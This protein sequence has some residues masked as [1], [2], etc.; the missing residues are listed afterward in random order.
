MGK[1]TDYILQPVGGRQ[2][3]ARGYEEIED[4][5]QKSCRR[6]AGAGDRPKLTGSGG[7]LDAQMVRSVRRRLRRLRGML[8]RN[9]QKLWRLH[10]TQW[11][12]LEAH[13]RRSPD[14]LRSMG[15]RRRHRW[16]G[17]ADLASLVDLERRQ[18]IGCECLRRW[19]REPNPPLARS[20][21]RGQRTRAPSPSR[22][23]SNAWRPRRPPAEERTL[24]VS[25]RGQRRRLRAH[26]R[27]SVEAGRSSKVDILSA[28]RLRPSWVESR[29]LVIGHTG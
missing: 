24:D 22:S 20:S 28:R 13:W 17:R 18:S 1:Q 3:G 15:R 12:C 9:L 10:R 2:S 8:G 29:R 14:R 6:G 16:P 19:P 5:Q 23:K 21:L 4:D 11:R 26:P 7:Q 27:R 25:S